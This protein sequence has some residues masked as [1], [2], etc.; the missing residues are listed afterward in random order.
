MPWVESQL[1]A[2]ARLDDE[3]IEHAF[4][5]LAASV[6]GFGRAHRLAF[7]DVGQADGAAKA[8]L[9]YCGVEAGRVPDGVND[10]DERLEFLCRPS[11]AMHRVV[12]LGGRWY[13]HAFGALLGSLDTGEAVALIPAGLGGYRYLDPRTGRKVRINAKVARRIAPEAVLFYR[14]LP[15]RRLSVGDL[16]RFIFD[17]FDASDYLVVLLAALAATLIGMQPAWANNIVFSVVVPSGK[18]A[19]IAPITVLLVGVAISTVL[20]N[21]CRNLVMQRVSLKVDVCCEA[22]T[23]S[24]V[25]SLPTSFL[26]QYASGDLSMRV[27]QVTLL[28]QQVTS[29]LLGS[30][31]TCVLSLVYLVQIAVYAHEL[32]VPA[33][34][35]VVIQALFIA[36]ASIVTAR[37]DRQTMRADASLSGVVTT[38]LSGIQKIKLAG[39]E[40]RA[41]AKWAHGYA[42]YARSAFNRPG[43]VRAIMPLVTTIGMVGTAVI[44]LM[45]GSSHVGVADYMSFNV[46][47]GQM[48]AAMLALADMAAQFAQIGPMLDMVAPILEA[49][50]ELASDKPM[51]EK[52]NGGIDVSG[53]S[54]RYDHDSPYVLR[55]LSFRVRPGEYVALVGKSG[56]GKSTVMRLL[57]GFEQPERGSIYYGRYDVAKVDL[58]S[59]RR[60]I[61]TVMQDSRLFMGDL[62][63]NITLS[64][65]TATLDDAW[66]AAELAGIADDIRKM[67]MGMQT[68]VTEGGGGVS[69]GQRQRIMI[70]RAICGNRRI[71][72][73]DEATSALDNVTQRHVSESLDS[74]KCT[75]LVIAHRLS[76]V[77]HCDR[78]LV[79]D[80]GAIAEEG[81]YDELI[82]AG[83]LFA[84]LVEHQRLDAET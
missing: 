30:G 81:T 51:V 54:F 37:Y 52:L 12:R 53:L 71:L 63:S 59:L 13:R 7:G 22:A 80:G 28:S 76:T 65:P 83:G 33:L 10:V 42:Q 84:E 46:A 38:L 49:E 60:S 58:R 36:V 26:K 69:G 78:I 32:V 62:A 61:G 41:L 79:L 45:A 2:R 9:R 4:S 19:L 23:F 6:A 17:V 27:S 8:C 72:M 34:V 67:P 21:A 56:C 11:G 31:L 55:N 50:P 3:M 40:D 1:Q 73:F 25:L 70:A 29:L 35:T 48:S 47:Y 77:Q 44:Y 39:A 68:I 57:L 75:R 15:L 82:A 43:Y 74:L 14:P 66:A 5:D 16:V 18:M 24:R 64:T 20:I